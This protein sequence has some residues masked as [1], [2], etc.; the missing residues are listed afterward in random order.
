M[1]VMRAGRARAMTLDRK[2]QLRRIVS[3]AESHPIAQGRHALTFTA[4]ERHR[5]RA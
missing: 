3:A 4:I 5:A 1:T 2:T